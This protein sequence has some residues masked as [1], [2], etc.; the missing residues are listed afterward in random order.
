MA[1]SEFSPGVHQR[2]VQFCVYKAKEKMMRL[3]C[4]LHTLRR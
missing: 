2:R 3:F 4:L 1:S